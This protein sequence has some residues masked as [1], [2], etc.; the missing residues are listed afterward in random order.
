MRSSAVITLIVITLIHP[1]FVSAQIAGPIG[2]LIVVGKI[3]TIHSVILEE[4]RPIWISVPASGVIP[5]K[6]YPVLYL[7][8]GD[9]HFY[10]VMGMIQ[11]LSTV[12]GNTVCP[13]MIVVGIPN[14]ARM[15]DLTPTHV[16]EAMGDTLFVEETGG[17]GK[18]TSF[19]EKELMPY[20]Q[21]NYPA[22]PYRMYIG[23]SLGGLAVIH[24]LLTRPDL[25]NSWVAIDPSLWWDDWHISKLADV[26]KDKK[27]FKDEALYLA[28]A[29]TMHN[30]MEVSEALKDTSMMTEHIRS[31]LSFSE[32]ATDKSSINGM[33]FKSKYYPDEDHSS[34][35]MVAE[36]DALKFLFTWY[37]FGMKDLSRFMDPEIAST[38]KELTDLFTNHYK[39]V[40]QH[41]GYEILPDERMINSLG[42]EFLAQQKSDLSFACFDMNVKNYPQ[43]SN[44]FDSMGDYYAV[45]GDDKMALEYF[46]KALAVDEV[47]LTREK[48]EA[49]KKK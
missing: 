38:P 23:H 35:P 43:S 45:Q 28:I 27:M 18:F 1:V 4:D 25:F 10:S 8:D 24:T 3:D 9:A 40:S 44:V 21:S 47:P 46:G 5:G 2:D 7:L 17:L 19:L 42:Y 16:D 6:I 32:A 37:T 22:A 49:L 11:Q 29:N 34:L 36:I 41:F 26:L 15:R 31:I 33:E 14:T 39:K 13:E 12:N 30:G 48:Y 20:I